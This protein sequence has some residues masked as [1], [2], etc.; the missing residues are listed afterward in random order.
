M[1]S[2]VDSSS[3]TTPLVLAV[4]HPDVPPSV[5]RILLDAGAAMTGPRDVYQT[6]NLAPDPFHYFVRATFL[7]DSTTGWPDL[8]SRSKHEI[9][10]PL[11]KEKLELVLSK[12]AAI[13][14]RMNEGSLA[15][16]LKAQPTPKMLECT[17]LFLKFFGRDV[18]DYRA[19]NDLPLATMIVRLFPRFLNDENTYSDD[20]QPAD[21]VDGY[22]ALLSM[23]IQHGL[24][25]DLPE[26]SL[27]AWQSTPLIAL[28][29][30]SIIYEV[31]ILKTG[32]GRPKRLST[33]ALE[34]FVKFL[35][36]NGASPT[37]R[38]IRGYNAMHYASRYLGKAAATA[39]LEKAPL[40]AFLAPKTNE[41]LGPESQPTDF[42][43]QV[44]ASGQ[45]ALDYG[46]DFADLLVTLG[47]DDVNV[48]DP[49]SH[50]PLLLAC[51]RGDSSLVRFLLEQ[52]ADPNLDA[53]PDTPLLMVTGLFVATLW[54]TNS[55]YEEYTGLREVNLRSS[56]VKDTRLWRILSPY[57][58]PIRYPTRRPR[59]DII[60]L[61][62]H[63]FPIEIR[64]DPWYS[65]YLIDDELVEI[66]KMLLNHGALLTPR[67]E[68]GNTAY[69][70]T[71]RWVRTLIGHIKGCPAR[72]GLADLLKE[73]DDM[74]DDKADDRPAKRMR[75][76][77]MQ[78]LDLLE[79]ADEA[80]DP[81][82]QMTQMY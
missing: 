3:I 73:A 30:P 18:I 57:G 63:S 38:D 39:L 10:D 77:L 36:D 31:S 28:C 65:L 45:A 8:M 70:Q 16:L 2:P 32:T 54:A 17:R 22:K 59:K 41:K 71:V 60:Q 27:L 35:L 40:S 74:E 26:N 1:A 80:D 50:S 61:D 68:S 58:P 7:H 5:V 34:E 53:A 19:Q 23:L 55:D 49:W 52:G 13:S 79:V 69:E 14:P 4:A 43:F 42:L 56:R 24:P 67:S 46:K 15:T 6:R 75:R 81:T 47:V 76:R 78:L 9:L 44:C 11:D 33:F 66:V 72:G 29:E 12:A 82:R 37:S 62:G 20:W 25:L 48:L 21:I 64:H 51:A